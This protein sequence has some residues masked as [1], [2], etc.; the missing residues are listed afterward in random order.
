[1]LRAAVGGQLSLKLRDLR[2]KDELAMREHRVDARAQG[3]AQAGLLGF[4]I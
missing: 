1:M 3:G 2:P 4:Q